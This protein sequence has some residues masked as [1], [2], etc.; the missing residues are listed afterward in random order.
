MDSQLT[1]AIRRLLA[2][3]LTGEGESPEDLIARLR[4]FAADADDILVSV[5]RA[6]RE[7]CSQREDLTRESDNEQSE[8]INWKERL[9]L[10][11]KNNDTHLVELARKKVD[12]AADLVSVLNGHLRDVQKTIEFLDIQQRAILVK[13]DTAKERLA[14]LSSADRIQEFREAAARMCTV[15]RRET[16]DS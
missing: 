13:K 1:S 11:T 2:T 6:H 15:N 10:A 3:D 8:V 4:R 9:E 16:A 5:A 14:M 7:A 12:A